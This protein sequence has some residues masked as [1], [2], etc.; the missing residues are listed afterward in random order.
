MRYLLLLA[1]LV[2]SAFASEDP[3]VKV[4]S[5]IISDIRLEEYRI[6]VR[7]P[8]LRRLVDRIGWIRRV[9]RC[10]EATLAIESREYPLTGAE[11][12]SVAKLANDYRLF[13]RDKGAVGAFFWLKSRP[14]ILF[15]APRLRRFGLEVDEEM[16]QYMEDLP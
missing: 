9:D 5:R 4:W 11:C 16:R 14:T 12:A 3:D 10:S 8:Q 2:L 1:G 6:Y 15:S 7:D 13:L